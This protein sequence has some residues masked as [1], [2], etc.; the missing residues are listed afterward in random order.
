MKI[1]SVGPR[2]PPCGRR[3]MMRLTVK[4]CNFFANAPKGRVIWE[5]KAAVILNLGAT[6][7]LCAEGGQIMHQ[8]KHQRDYACA[9]TLH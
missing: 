8:F 5:T 3:D 9:I 4:I 1:G 7:K 2:V 6:S